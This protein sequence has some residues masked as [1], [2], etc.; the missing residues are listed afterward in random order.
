MN[1]QPHTLLLID[2][3]PIFRLGLRTL[4][5]Q[6]SDSLVIAEADSSTAA[7]LILDGTSELTSD[8]ASASSSAADSSEPTTD[9]NTQ[10]H[11]LENSLPTRQ[12]VVIL[13]LALMK[14][15]P[16][17][18]SGLELCQELKRRYPHMPILLLSSLRSPGLLATAKAV[19]VE[20]YCP[21]GSDPAEIVTAVQRVASGELYGWDRS[22]QE[23]QMLSHGEIPDQFSVP[24]SPALRPTLLNRWLAYWRRSGLRQIDMVLAEIAQELALGGLSWLDREVVL[25]RQRELRVARW[26]VSHSLPDLDVAAMLQRSTTGASSG[27]QAPKHVLLNR[28]PMPAQVTAQAAK[29]P[30]YALQ[31]VEVHSLDARQ[32]RVALW[33][34]TV[35]QLQSGLANLTN[36]PMEI[37]ILQ[38]DVKRQLLYLVLQKLEDVLEDLRFSQVEPEQLTANRSAILRDLWEAVVTDFMG[39]YRSVQVATAHIQVV[40]VLLLEATAIQ[41]TLLDKIP[42]VTELLAHLLFLSPLTIDQVQHHAGSPDAMRRAEVLLHNMIIQVANAAVQPILNRFATLEVI[43]HHFYDRKLLSTREIER[44]RNNL[45]WKYRLDQYVG[46]PTAIFQS[47]WSLLVLSDRGIKT[48]TIYANRDQELAALQGIPALVTLTLELR[49]AIAPRVQAAIALVGSSL[50]YFLTDV[51]GRGIGLIGRGVIKGIGS[52][53]QDLKVKEKPRSDS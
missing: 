3:D 34:S 42:Q 26:L 21:K 30:S 2:E 50:V 53:F 5:A 35:L 10:E 52:A 51:V 38:T 14:S 11:S 19:G 13:D 46:E 44:F 41:T 39:K 31:P 48:T 45:S 47:Q 49:D 15:T 9:T 28:Q 36:S 29:E 16:D 12:Y 17:S 33:D 1:H 22:A 7:L 37:D 24:N 40:E 43:K 20:G 18:L 4:L 32:L 25:G 23:D 6:M 27:L 8:I